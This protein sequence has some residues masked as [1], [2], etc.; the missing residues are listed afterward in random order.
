M[1]ITNKVK[2]GCCRVAT[3]SSVA[4][5][6]STTCKPASYAKCLEQTSAEFST[7][8]HTPLDLI[9]INPADN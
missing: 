7:P 2:R 5:P 4:C 9:L 1:T 3:Y 6:T 8:H